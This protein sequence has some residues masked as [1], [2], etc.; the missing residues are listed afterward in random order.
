MRSRAAAGAA[1]FEYSH[2]SLGTDR[3]DKSRYKSS[4]SSPA[5]VRDLSR[6]CIVQIQPRKPA[7]DHA[8]FLGSTRQHGLLMDHT[9]SGIDLP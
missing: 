6:V 9:K 7:L 2:F 4:S 8:L 5:I 3:S 1:R